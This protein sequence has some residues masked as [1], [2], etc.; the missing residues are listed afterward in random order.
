MIG[1]AVVGLVVAAY[2]ARAITA[3]TATMSAVYRDAYRAHPLIVGGAT[4]FLVSHLTGYLPARFDPLRHL[5]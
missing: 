3:G 4:A 1:W 2:D 5:T